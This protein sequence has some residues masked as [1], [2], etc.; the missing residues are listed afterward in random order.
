MK[1][2][3]GGG[4]EYIFS[5]LFS[6]GRAGPKFDF[7]HSSVGSRNGFTLLKNKVKFWNGAGAMSYMTNGFVIYDYKF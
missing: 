4:G 7:A 5:L 3:G 6:L 2:G 1:A